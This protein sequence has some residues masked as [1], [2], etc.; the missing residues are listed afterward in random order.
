LNG[1]SIDHK[2]H[3][4][5]QLHENKKSGKEEIQADNDQSSMENEKSKKSSNTKFQSDEKKHH[6]ELSD[7][8]T[9]QVHEASTN[10][11]KGTK[12][13][14]SKAT[15]K[16]SSEHEN[17]L[18]TNKLHG[19]EK[20][21]KKTTENDEEKNRASHKTEVTDD[22]EESSNK[23][24]K[25][26]TT[27]NQMDETSQMDEVSGSGKDLETSKNTL[28]NKKKNV[29]ETLQA[30]SLKMSTDASSVLD[31]TTVTTS[32]LHDKSSNKQ[33]TKKQFGENDY[34]DD[35]KVSPKLSKSA[36]TS[37]TNIKKESNPSI[38]LVSD[39]A[40]TSPLTTD[41]EDSIN[42][43]IPDIS[44]SDN[45]RKKPEEKTERTDADNRLNR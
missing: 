14:N 4:T 42:T 39:D 25:F 12:S 6:K 9:G 43:N 3:T 36:S 24:N 40:H 29:D 20:P 31:D 16:H 22:K 35:S 2:N 19:T 15:D 18:T 38:A 1:T 41:G 44:N 34:N 21:N 33:M 5:R 23:T 10:H 26:E 17:T 7:K 37:D 27:S 30:S 11:V 45:I 28:S 32:A 13:D 8:G